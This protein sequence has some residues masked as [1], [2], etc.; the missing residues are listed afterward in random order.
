MVD[1]SRSIRIRLPPL[2]MGEVSL[3]RYNVDKRHYV[4]VS[5]ENCSRRKTGVEK[6]ENDLAGKS[7]S[8][9]VL[10]YIN[11]NHPFDSFKEL[12]TFIFFVVV[13]YQRLY[14]R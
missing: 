3:V 14:T 6:L 12:L 4:F 1:Q 11:K 13:I 10:L 9:G 8:K 5:T 7:L 2:K